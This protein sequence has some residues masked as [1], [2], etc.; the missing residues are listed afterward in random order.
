LPWLRVREQ[1]AET[2]NILFCSFINTKHR[3]E[4]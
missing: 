4:G 1:S 2:E 3:V